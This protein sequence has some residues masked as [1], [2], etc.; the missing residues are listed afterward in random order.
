[1]GKTEKHQN[2]LF[3]VNALKVILSTFTTTFLTSHIVNL[4]PDN[5][6]GQGVFNIGLMYCCQFAA[7]IVIYFILS[8]LSKKTNRAV[9]FRMGIVIY[10][11]LLVAIVLF[12]EDIAELIELTGVLL[13]V[14]E[15]FYASSYIV[16]K[17]ELVSQQ[18]ILHSN[19]KS[20]KMTNTLTSFTPIVLGFL[21]DYTTYPR[22]AFFAIVI[23]IIQFLVSFR[24]KPEEPIDTTFRL[25]DYWS[26]LKRNK[27]YGKKV[28]VTYFDALFAGVKNTYKIL[29]VILTIYIF[30]TNISLGIITTV[31]SFI[32]NFLLKRYK[33]SESVSKKSK[34]L[35]YLALG[36]LPFFSACAFVY[37]PDKITLII[38]NGFLHLATQFSE[39]FGN[40][41]RDAIIKNI[42]H[43]EFIAEHQFIY[44]FFMTLSIIGSYGLFMYVGLNPSTE[45][46]Q[47]LLL[48]FTL[49]N[50][51]RFILLYI[52]RK[53][54]I[55]L[56]Y[57]NNQDSYAFNKEYQDFYV[58]PDEDN[59]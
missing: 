47:I 6:L 10:A 32:T 33:K 26:Y 5:I 21:I 16:I 56:E 9:F 31:F 19:L 37:Y 35:A 53:V 7:Y 2:A 3:L 29:S 59:K 58:I 4:T 38:L 17:N 54:R 49:V 34:L 27:Y 50:P 48:A 57:K 43:Q 52:Q 13:G 46:F 51:I 12:G 15:A 20:M 30:K 11:I 1:M 55:K 44:E 39:Y 40:C 42:N 28:K 18:N 14:G 45:A 25:K 24:V 23:A 36:F 41:E 22:I 8:Y